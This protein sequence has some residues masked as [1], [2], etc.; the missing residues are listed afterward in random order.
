MIET[1]LEKNEIEDFI[2]SNNNAHFL[3]SPEWAKVKKNWKNEILVARDKDGKI[4]GTMSILLKK[5]PFLK[6]HI[7]Y[8]PRGFV[9]DKNDELAI[10]YLITKAKEL[11]KR[12]NAFVLKIDPCIMQS[13]EKSRKMLVS[14]G[15]KT[16]KNIKGIDDVIQPKYVM[17]LNIK[18]K[19]ENDIINEF[20]SKTR[21]NIRLAIKKGVTIREGNEQDIGIFY[22]IL[23]ETAKRDNFVIREKSYYQRVF[24]LLGTKHVKILIAE[25]DGKPIATAMPILYG[26]K[27]WYLYGGSKNIYRNLMPTYL[28]QWEMIKWAIAEKCDIYD[29]RGITRL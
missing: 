9:C 26:N 19:N 27:V 18:G 4:V 29:F 22:R 12:Y 13:D 5:M 23:K 17:R 10:T 11:A 16:K 3:Q 21:Y 14:L 7:M 20:H 2:N 1:K 8:A 24:S 25:F 28:L 6:Y 15:F